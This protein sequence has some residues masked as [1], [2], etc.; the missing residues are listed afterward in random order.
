MYRV[1][2]DNADLMIN[3]LKHIKARLDENSKSTVY[4]VGKATTKLAKQ[5]APKATG[6]LVRSINFNKSGMKG[7]WRSVILMK[8][9]QN[10]NYQGKIVNYGGMI[11]RGS[12]RFVKGKGNPAYGSWGDSTGANK[13]IGFFTKAINYAKDTYP[14][15]MKR[16]VRRVIKSY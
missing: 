4:N 5:L 13:S 1:K 12:V 11:D 8:P 2:I 10:P 9:Q 6:A 14:N 15:E 7:G 16:M 3:R